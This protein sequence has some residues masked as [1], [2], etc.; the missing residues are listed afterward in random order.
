MWRGRASR[1]RRV[2][3]AVAP[4]GRLI[5]CHYRNADEPVVDVEGVLGEVE[6]AARAP[7]VRVAWTRV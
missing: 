3:R 7:G 4:G 6:G 2:R 5:V 1:E